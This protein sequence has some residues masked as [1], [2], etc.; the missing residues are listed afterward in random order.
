MLALALGLALARTPILAFF[1]ALVLDLTIAPAF[2]LF[3][4]CNHKGS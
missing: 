1:V 3:F 2:L 4:S